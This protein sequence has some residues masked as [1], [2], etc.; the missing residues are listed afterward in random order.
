MRPS[1][2]VATDPHRWWGTASMLIGLAIVSIV[3]LT[4]C[5]PE[6]STPVPSGSAPPGPSDGGPASA[7][8]AEPGG[9]AP[10]TGPV[11]V[12]PFDAF[13]ADLLCDLAVY[14]DAAPLLGTGDL[15]WEAFDL[16]PAGQTDIVGCRI[17]PR[18][19]SFG[20]LE[21]R[22][23]SSKDKNEL[24]L[25]TVPGGYE[26]E[27]REI[28]AQTN[29]TPAQTITLWS[30]TLTVVMKG[31]YVQLEVVVDPRDR[32]LPVTEDELFSELQA[33]LIAAGLTNG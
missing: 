12:P 29:D 28:P 2:P 19:W 25:L 23:A 16:T 14:V 6:E 31:I 20:V 33:V 7:G 27:A 10:W 22:G 32:P 5:G 18:S 15:A 3:G 9:G 24:L 4:G 21:L 17:L 30:S 13:T 1:R 26:F 8:P 11:P